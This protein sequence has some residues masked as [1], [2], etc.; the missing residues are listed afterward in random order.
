MGMISKAVVVFQLFQRRQIVTHVFQKNRDQL[1]IVPHKVLHR[2][3]GPI[4]RGLIL[5]FDPFAPI[6]V[7]QAGLGEPSP[8]VIIRVDL[9]RRADD[10]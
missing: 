7:E 5:P 1:M 6:L 2:A 3:I 9:A 10:R 4:G 8:T